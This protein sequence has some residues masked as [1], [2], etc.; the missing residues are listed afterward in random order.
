[1]L[2]FAHGAGTPPM[3]ANALAASAQMTGPDSASPQS[4]KQQQQ[5]QERAGKPAAASPPPRQPIN[6]NHPA[7]QLARAKMKAAFGKPVS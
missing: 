4:Q 2:A 6:P 5:P 3:D 7:A 1:M